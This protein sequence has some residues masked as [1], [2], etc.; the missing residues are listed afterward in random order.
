MAQYFKI[1]KIIYSFINPTCIGYVLC[2]TTYKG[3]EPHQGGQKGSWRR[4][5]QE[6]GANQVESLC[7]REPGGFKGLN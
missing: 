3:T 1:K 7:R 6:Q 5:R 2:K 4:G